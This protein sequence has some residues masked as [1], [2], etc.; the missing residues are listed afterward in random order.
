MIAV[1]PPTEADLKALRQLI[2]AE[3]IPVDLT[4]EDG[5]RTVVIH[6]HEVLTDQVEAHLLNLVGHHIARY[7]L[8][9]IEGPAQLPRPPK[10]HWVSAF[11]TAHPE[12]MDALVAEARTDR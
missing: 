9:R 5:S 6:L 11:L 10:A 3:D 2:A 1:D 7:R 4:V 12:Y 8:D